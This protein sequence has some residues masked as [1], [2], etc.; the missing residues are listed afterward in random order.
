VQLKNAVEDQKIK[1][2]ES[3]KELNAVHAAKKRVEQEVKLVEE[4]VKN[5]ILQDYKQ[6]IRG[7][8]SEKYEL[9]KS[10]DKATAELKEFKTANQKLKDE[11]WDT[12]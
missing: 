2:K 3:V 4:R 10:L 6:I 7:L 8:E 12:I 9:Q 11:L 5:E 1:L